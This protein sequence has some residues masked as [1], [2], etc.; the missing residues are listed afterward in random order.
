MK[1]IQVSDETAELLARQSDITGLSEAE[2]VGLWAR[3]HDDAPAHGD[4]AFER[5]LRD[6]VAADLAHFLAD[7]STGIPA[8]A[9]LD[10]IRSRD[11]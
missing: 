8:D 3:E 2:L 4:A 5:W 6:E 10:R 1:T 7:P 11:S 9:V